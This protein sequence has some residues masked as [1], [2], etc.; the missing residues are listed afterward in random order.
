VVLRQ[1]CEL[2]GVPL[3]DHLIVTEDAVFSFRESE[4]WVSSGTTT[5][6]KQSIG[7]AWHA[8]LMLTPQESGAKGRSPAPPEERTRG[9]EEP[10]KGRC[11][12]LFTAG[13]AAAPGGLTN[14]SQLTA[15]DRTPGPGCGSAVSQ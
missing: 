7:R 6:P 2:I 5:A 8:R 3:L 4:R 9:A 14:L 13:R 10:V 11:D 15:L 1:A 12:S